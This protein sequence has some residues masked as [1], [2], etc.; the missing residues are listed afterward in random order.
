[1]IQYHNGV[2]TTRLD[3][4]NSSVL[5]KFPATKIVASP[6][7]GLDHIDLKE[8]EKR[9]IK[10]ISLRGENKFL[11]T[12][13]ATAEHTMGLMLSLLRKIPW[14]HHHVI[15][16]G[17]D[18]NK[19]LGH[20]LNG[21]T[22]LIIGYGRLGKIVARYAKAFGMKIITIDKTDEN[23]SKKR[24][25]SLLRKSD[26]VTIHIHLDNNE[27][28]FDKTCFAHMKLGSFLINTSR[29]GVIDETALLKAL[30]G[31]IAGAALDVVQNEPEASPQLLGYASSHTN[32]LITSHIGGAT[33]ESTKKTE[34]F[35]KN[36]IKKYVN[37]SKKGN[38]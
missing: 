16:G 7:T 3:K 11:K 34:E 28:F 35:I 20:E 21:K 17:W 22:L 13:P 9:G 18:R 15:K 33:H 36:K 32:L 23:Y 4:V 2:L 14:S 31:R 5:D 26:I 24:L 27:E 8:C 10:V 37:Q 1:M 19:W 12:I 25:Y 38:R 6:T 30:K 29:G